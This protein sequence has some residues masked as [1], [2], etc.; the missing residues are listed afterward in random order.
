MSDLQG[1]TAISTVSLITLIIA[2]RW[3]GISKIIIVALIIRIIILLIGHYIVPLP[4]STSDALGFERE[5]WNLAQNGFFY[6]LSNMSLS[7]FVFFSSLHAIPY[8]LF[9]R[10]I[11]M[12]QSISLLFGIGTI[13]FSW[14]LSKILWDN[15]TANKVGW[16]LALFPSVVLYSVLYLREIYVSFFLVLALYGAVSWV[17]YN[18]YKSIILSLMGF[19]GASLFHGPMIVGFFIFVI[20]VFLNHL[21]V[22]LKSLAYFRI[23]VKKFII[24]LLCLTIIGFYLTNKITIQYLGTF[25]NSINV[26]FLL[27]KTSYAYS[28]LSSWPEW[29]KATNGFE[30]LYKAPLRSIYFVFSPFPWDVKKSEHFIGLFDSLLYL[31]LVFLILCNIK[32][33][34]RDHALRLILIILLFYIL[35]YGF[36]VG[37]FGTSIRHKSKFALMFI[38]LAA[39]LIKN[40]IFKKKTYITII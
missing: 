11:L 16:T 30:L 39:P 32:V 35:V 10:S 20:F 9:G 8:S 14:K 5:A 23:N 17:K 37:N 24:F 26:D 15:H 33:I 27:L 3:P 31:Y 13:F 40:L 12:G 36:G 6:I 25:K 7:P 2:L 28:G 22:L 38:I 19:V 4:D 18:N 34:W 29:T 1:F 21:K